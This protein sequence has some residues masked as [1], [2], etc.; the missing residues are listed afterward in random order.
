MGRFLFVEGIIIMTD[1]DTHSEWEVDLLDLLAR[2]RHLRARYKRQCGDNAP[3]SIDDYLELISQE[4]GYDIDLKAVSW[5]SNGL[6]RGA[7]LP[8]DGNKAKIRVPL[9]VDA[10]PENGATLCE[11]RYITL[12][13]GA[14]LVVDDEDSYVDDYLALV[15]TIVFESSINEL[16]KDGRSDVFYGKIFAMELLFPAELRDDVIAEIAAGLSTFDAAKRFL[17]PEKELIWFLSDRVHPGL[18]HVR[19]IEE[20]LEGLFLKTVH[21]EAGPD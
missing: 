3:Y 5:G 18:K 13:E 17:I 4:T 21:P 7:C 20:R 14:H 19:K 16:K 15:N 11:Q 12:K 10:D 6:I 8:F 1:G 2:A 9:F